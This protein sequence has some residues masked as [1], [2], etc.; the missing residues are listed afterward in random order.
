LFESSVS[1]CDE[2]AERNP[3]TWNSELR[4]PN[5]ELRDRCESVPFDGKAVLSLQEAARFQCIR[6]SRER[7]GCARFSA[8]VAEY[9][10]NKAT[11]AQRLGPQIIQATFQFQLP[12]FN[13]D[14]IRPSCG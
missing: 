14:L 11:K 12:A 2:R 9:I 1:Q 7:L 10:Y 3:E 6:K 4:M 5:I 13:L 8:A